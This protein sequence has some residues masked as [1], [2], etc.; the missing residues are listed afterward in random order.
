MIG[1][2][3]PL[4]WCTLRTR[5][6]SLQPVRGV[7]R[8]VL[9][10]LLCS[11]G[12]MILCA[13]AL[14]A[15]KTVRLRLAWGNNSTAKQ[16]WFGHV[17]IAGGTLS[18]LQPLGIE[19]DAPVALRIE[20]QKLVIDPLEK[21]GYDGCDITV[22]ADEQAVIHF[23]FRNEQSPHGDTFDVPLQ[24]VIEGHVSRPID[25]LGSILLAHRS[26]GD[27]LR[28]LPTRKNLVFDPQEIWNLQLQPDLAKELERGPLDLEL[29]VHTA[30]NNT[31][32]WQTSRKY[33]S[34][35]QIEGGLE[36]DIECPA[37]QG[38]YRLSI[39]ARAPEGFATRFVPG[40][41][42]KP[43]AIR[44]VDFVVIDPQ[45]K[46][47]RLVDH[48]LPVLTVD[49][50]NPSWW[51]RLPNWTKVPQLRNRT[52]GSVG[53]VRPVVSPGAS[54][55]L[56]ELPPS[57]NRIDPYWQAYTLPIREPGMPHSLEIEV[58]RD[59]PTHLT[60]NV[61]EP[62]AAGRV[63]T[64]VQDLGLY[65][66]GD[67]ILRDR[68]MV[69]HRIMFW[70]RTKS[71]VLLMVNRHASSP[72]QYGKIRLLRHDDQIAA[73]SEVEPLGEQS[74]MIAGY[75]SQPRFAESFGS[76]EE[77]DETIGLSVQGWSTFLQGTERLAQ[78]LRLSGYNSVVLTVAAD[79]SAIYPSETINPSPRYDTGMRAA[80]GRDPMR[81]DVL[82][83][84]LRVFDR[85]GLRV[86][87][88]L[89]LA[90]P[91][92]RLE[93]LRLSSNPQR[94]GITW[95][96]SHGQSW[97]DDHRTS[98]GLGSFYNPLNAQVQSE[99][100]ALVEELT[101]RYRQHPSFAGVGI[102]VSGEGYQVL[103]NEAWGMDDTTIARFAEDANVDFPA[104]G[105]KRFRR[106]A[107]Q[108][109]G[110][111][112]QQW[113]NWRAAELSKLYE[114]LAEIVT[115]GRNDLHLL[116]ATEDLFAGR[117]MQ[118]QV[119]QTLA[120]GKDLNQVLMKHGLDMDRLENTPGIL[121]LTPHLLGPDDRLQDRALD[122]RIN[123][124]VEQS[125]FMHAD[126]SSSM[127][128][129]HATSHSKLD[130]F[131]Q[132]GPFGPEQT[133]LTLSS[134]PLPAGAE[135]CREIVTDFSRSDVSTFVIGGESLPLVL[136]SQFRSILRTLQQLPTGLD[137]VRTQ[138]AQP[139]V[140]RVYRSAHATTVA[141]ANQS[142]WNIQVRI[143]FT[144]SEPCHWNKLGGTGRST[145]DADPLL[146]RLSPK[147]EDWQVE[148]QPYDLQAWHFQDGKL[149]IGKPQVQ[150]DGSI[151]Q[152]LLARIEE[153]ESRT[154]NLD[155]QR[156]YPQL[157]NHSFELED[158]GVRIAG[159]QPRYGTTGQVELIGTN[160]HSGKNALRLTS[161]DQLGVA[162]QSH[163]FPMPETGQLAVHAFVRA[164]QLE[165]TSRL[166][167]TLEDATNENNY[168]KSITLGAE[169]PLGSDWT[170]YEFAVD[171]VPFND[172][173]Q[174]RV[175]FHLTGK[176]EVLLDD[177]HLFDLRF[178]DARR[179][180]LV[181]RIY[182]AKLALEQD[183]V[184]DCLRV[185]DEYWTRY[186]VEY[187]PP[188]RSSMEQLARQ[189]KSP[190]DPPA[191][192]KKEGVGSWLRG[193][194]PTI[195]R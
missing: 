79:G 46:L 86:I 174:M 147:P 134:Q 187:V 35:S 101:G 32:L 60:I 166:H 40:Q 5:F 36:F 170:S 80:S 146:G 136:N 78:S 95:I 162:V 188:P 99:V 168:Q 103:P 49:P 28:V 68:E 45:A 69:V 97:L 118:Q 185:I 27:K 140:L 113:I 20:K 108:L 194:V 164:N 29:K 171:D 63:T 56:V 6:A 151:K 138:S 22:V 192:K 193:W 1:Q 156:P 125:E 160:P 74:R 122:M 190:A 119:R 7:R 59:M 30:D 149:R 124:A 183:Q 44:D 48:W 173:G 106:R 104:E 82:E 91:L 179:G 88:A 112:R 70:P 157:Q 81:K 53:N 121:A 8:F 137:E 130:S 169:K 165:P 129:H 182:A 84:L 127:L 85:E 110:P 17:A 73:P 175:R 100:N 39:A 177:V 26:P 18:D 105:P 23:E 98:G 141:L 62:D 55:A 93:Q 131:D 158:T 109:L 67:Q 75:I 191:E 13:S 180:A 115:A 57:S 184:V 126:Q 102:Q 71:P 42:A 176:G 178:D 52:P 64:G 51:Q 34:D 116:L 38:A 90:T 77:F 117:A 87:P 61:I 133:H 11:L 143:P 150:F 31:V 12:G 24:D 161:R 37:E 123:S 120:D 58:P 41:Q 128:V 3:R 92:P 33:T 152:D 181:K 145:S 43:L 107:D 50:A 89:Q 19:A 111:L 10:A 4:V 154:G 94:T 159:W 76:S 114:Q 83:M 47:A 72:A 142:P 25:E 155:I 148:L 189:P 21:R 195:W 163:W 66:S 153:I 2:G 16:R 167:V 172:S 96:G 144:S 65:H 15:E 14:G 54:G 186:L 132:R 9:A 139:V 135:Q